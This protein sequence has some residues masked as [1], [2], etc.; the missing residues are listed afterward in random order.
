MDIYIEQKNYLLKI[1]EISLNDVA[2]VN[3]WHNSDSLYETLVGICHHPS[4]D[5]DYQWIFTYLSS[6]RD[7]KFIGIIEISDYPIGIIK[8]GE[9]NKYEGAI[10][11]FIGDE[12]NQNKGWGYL[13]LHYFLEYL[14]NFLH[15]Q[16]FVLVVLKRNERAI[17]LY[18]KCGFVIFEEKLL[19]GVNK[20][21]EYVYLMKK[22]INL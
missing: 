3:K 11:M 16:N 10:G 19:D 5:T 4:L 15:Y 18:E 22:T 13:A 6:P 7:E 12:E 21:A 20:K 8:F 14:T 1:R 2:I 9:T 17:H